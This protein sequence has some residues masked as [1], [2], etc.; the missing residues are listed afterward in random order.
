MELP[1]SDKLVTLIPD[2][3]LAALH[4]FVD[5]LETNE[6]AAFQ[7][8]WKVLS[9]ELDGLESILNSGVPA[10]VSWAT[11][12]IMRVVTPRRTEP[13]RPA[14]DSFDRAGVA[15]SILEV[16]LDIEL[17][18]I[19]VRRHLLPKQMISETPGTDLEALERIE[20]CWLEFLSHRSP[21]HGEISLDGPET[22]GL[23]LIT[24]IIE[25]GL[26]APG[27]QKAALDLLWQPHPIRITGEGRYLWLAATGT[28]KA[29]ASIVPRRV[30]LTP[31]AAVVLASHPPPSR[32]LPPTLT[33][34]FQAIAQRWSLRPEDTPPLKALC[35][36][37]AL[38]LRLSEAA[39]QFVVDFAE[40]KNES[41]SIAETRWRG[42]Y[43]L[44][45]WADETDPERHRPT[46]NAAED[47]GA[48]PIDARR[49]RGHEALTTSIGRVLSKSKDS[50]ECLAQLK[51]IP[52]HGDA[53]NIEKCLLSWLC[54]NVAESQG[55]RNGSRLSTIQLKFSALSPR[56]VAMIHARPLGTLDETDWE[57]I[58][59]HIADEDVSG[60]RKS[61]IFS[62]LFQFLTWAV[63]E[64]HLSDRP[65]KRSIGASGSLVNATVLTHEEMEEIVEDL[66]D[67]LN[68][69]PF[70]QRQFQACVLSLGYGSGLRR[71]EARGVL[72]EEV[73]MREPASLLLRPNAERNLKTDS[74]KRRVALDLLWPV[75]NSRTGSFLSE[76]GIPWLVKKDSLKADIDQVFR[77]LNKLI[78]E[79]TGDPNAKEHSGRHSAATWI[80][81][82][83]YQEDLKLQDWLGLWPFLGP[84][85]AMGNRLRRTLLGLAGGLHGLHAVRSLLGHRHESMTLRHYIHCIDMMLLAALALATP[86]RSIETIFGAAGRRP[87]S[88]ADR[89]VA[90]DVLLA[91]LEKEQPQRF[92][93][94]DTPL[95]GIRRT[96]PKGPLELDARKCLHEW[97][98]VSSKLS[99]EVAA[100]TCEIIGAERAL[101]Q[102]INDRKLVS[103]VRDGFPISHIDELRP[104]SPAE[105]K[106]ALSVAH[107]MASLIIKPCSMS[108][109]VQALF[110]S[111]LLRGGLGCY[112]TP[113]ESVDPMATG[114]RALIRAG[115]LGMSIHVEKRGRTETG[116]V[117][118]NLIALENSHSECTQPSESPIIRIHSMDTASGGRFSHQAFVWSMAMAAI[119]AHPGTQ[120]V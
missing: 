65:I 2:D 52:V 100:V 114:L 111:H 51:E 54:H 17:P 20:S 62:A 12:R 11:D 24:L 64:G 47:A 68:P 97:L 44:A 50:A 91:R 108:A 70:A 35:R 27:Y 113:S 82:T 28:R 59:E 29:S 105:M 21:P 115:G 58:Q 96:H 110:Q 43:G 53:S 66:H 72:P 25:C 3:R 81:L 120:N 36:G 37:I 45:P 77:K 8:V 32:T 94:E 33:V 48:E 14:E 16:L 88:G 87:H 107:G 41:Q 26:L 38:R 95:E 31:L 116:S 63:R 6:Q 5:G 106:T 49:G 13:S 78:A 93:R 85:V 74:S 4:A 61:T 80:L 57:Q 99:T 103:K 60:S 10:R 18:T 118:R 23:L 89:A 1:L 39:P 40:G 42:M 75:S 55:K 119:A 83:L 109:M 76:G 86:D 67:P 79:V 71:G 56:L 101:V 98:E 73:S 46:M 34:A 69:L 19:I 9:G 92:R 112:R 84:L 104:T 22:A 30:H 90:L 15:R 117:Q 7:Q 102:I